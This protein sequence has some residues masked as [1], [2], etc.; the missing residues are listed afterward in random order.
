MPQI[1]HCGARLRRM[2][3]GAAGMK[4]PTASPRANCRAISVSESCTKGG[5]SEAAVKIAPV[6]SS[7]R[8]VPNTVLIHAAAGVT[9]ICAAEKIVLTHDP[10]SKPRLSAPRMSAKP[11]VVIRT[12]RVEMNAPTSTATTR[13]PDTRS[14]LLQAAA[15]ARPLLSPAWSWRRRLGVGK[16]RRDDRHPRPQFA[17]QWVVGC[18][19]QFDRDP[20][21]DFGEIA[22]RIVRREQAELRAARRRDAVDDRVDADLGQLTDRDMGQLGFLVVG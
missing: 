7:T 6:H 5:N 21:H 19:P 11:C 13:R 10:S 8:R 4:A 2:K 17:G 12:L 20:L 3:P 16:D 15:S 22:G 14:A 1:H 18:D 9:T